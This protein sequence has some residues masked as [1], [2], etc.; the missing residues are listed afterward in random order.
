MQ[1]ELVRALTQPERIQT[2]F[3]LEGIS[4]PDA[5]ARDDYLPSLEPNEFNRRWKVVV[6]E[7]ALAALHSTYQAEGRQEV[8]H[9]LRPS[10]TRRTV[11]EQDA[12]EMEGLRQRLY[13]E[14][15][16]LVAETVTTPTGL[17][18]ELAELFG[19]S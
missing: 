13:D 8:F 7:Q 1:S 9:R 10:L 11:A 18:A 6:L 14:V 2:S 4:L 5:E 3:V 16:R 15:R 12:Q 19:E 17:E